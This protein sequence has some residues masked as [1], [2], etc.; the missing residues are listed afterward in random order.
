MRPVHVLHNSTSSFAVLDILHFHVK[1][2]TFILFVKEGEVF[3]FFPAARAAI[4]A[5]SGGPDL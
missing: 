1:F 2:E 4:K 5:S 3:D